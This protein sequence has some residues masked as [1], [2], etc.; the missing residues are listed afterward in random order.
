MILQFLK[1]NKEDGDNMVEL[2]VWQKQ[3]IE[4]RLKD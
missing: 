2:A 1:D 4:D 3:I